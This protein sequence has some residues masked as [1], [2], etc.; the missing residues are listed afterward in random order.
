MIRFL[1]LFLMLA[2]TAC[3]ASGQKQLPMTGITITRVDGTTMRLGVEV[4]DEPAEQAQGLMGR[5][6][7]PEDKGM[8]FIFEREEEQAFW[9]H[10]T[11]IPLDII[12][13]DA[14]GRIVFIHHRAKPQS[15][16]KIA[17]RFPAKLVLEV[18]G[19]VSTRRNIRVGDTITVDKIDAG[20]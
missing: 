19:G 8:L 7:L 18:N 6:M 20:N 1:V 16:A 2:I 10:D 4:A 11:L 15:D 3:D 5:T 17:S 12:F 14:A 13:A 9:M